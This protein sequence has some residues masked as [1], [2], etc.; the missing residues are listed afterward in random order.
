MTVA[1]TGKQEF[2]REMSELSEEELQERWVLDEAK[3]LSSKYYQDICSVG[4]SLGAQ[5]ITSKDLLFRKLKQQLHQELFTFDHTVK[6]YREMVASLTDL[7]LAANL[8]PEH[9]MLVHWYIPFSK[10]IEL[11]HNAIRQNEPKKDRNAYGNYLVLMEPCKLAVITMCVYTCVS[12]GGAE[13][14]LLRWNILI[15]MFFL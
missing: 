13:L 10:A 1:V 3:T 7:G 8:K 11:E 15:Y 14:V 5:T 12:V 9:R 2:L 6:I 4:G